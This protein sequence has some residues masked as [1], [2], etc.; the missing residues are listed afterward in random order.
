MACFE[1]K[2]CQLVK[3]SRRNHKIGGRLKKKVFILTDALS[4][5]SLGFSNFAN[6]NRQNAQCVKLEDTC[7]KTL[8]LQRNSLFSA[9]EFELKTLLNLA[10]TLY[11]ADARRDGE[12]ES[13]RNGFMA[14]LT[15]CI[16]VSEIGIV[17]QHSDMVLLS[18]LACIHPFSVTHVQIQLLSHRH[19]L[20]TCTT[21]RT[22]THIMH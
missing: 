1:L 19:I 10:A 2:H 5:L 20:H 21:R 12:E 17:C 11:L 13:G 3:W 9:S 6:K 14:E 22:E 8:V 15:V 4:S 16:S 18:P 7:P